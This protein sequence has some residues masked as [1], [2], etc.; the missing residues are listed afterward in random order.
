MSET[1]DNSQERE[2][3]QA[4]LQAL[5]WQLEMGADEALEDEAPDHYEVSRAQHREKVTRANLANAAQP[6]KTPARATGPGASPEPA[7]F[8]PKAGKLQSNEAAVTEAREA[9]AAAKD[10]AALRAAVETFEGCP[11]KKTAMSCVFSDGNPEAGLMIL[12]EAPG[13]NEDR[14]GLPFVG[15]AGQL[16]DRMLAAIGR[17][18][19]SAYISNVLFWRPPGNRTPTPEE[20]ASCL[21]FVEKHIALAK[22]KALLLVGGSSAGALLNLGKGVMRLRGRWYPYANSFLETP[23][24]AMVTL[25]PAYLLRQPGQKRLAWRDLLELKSV[26]ESDRDPLAS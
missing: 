16:L 10:L 24:P 26:L 20:V 1:P 17:D 7:V 9:A 19:T 11:L 22:P 3:R 14:Q 21:P 25:H 23:L 8:E 6:Q 4:L 13:A 15:E 18:R 5:A 2:E 12:G